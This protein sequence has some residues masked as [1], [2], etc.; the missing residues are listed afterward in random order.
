MISYDIVSAIMNWCKCTNERE[1][2]QLIETQLYEREISIGEF[3]KAVMKI[4]AMV[5]ELI[6]MCESTNNIELM[7]KLS[8][9]DGLILKFITTN[10]SLYI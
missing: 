6:K 5:N 1:C 2:K 3:T 8:L 7:H 10:Q 9:V 4:S